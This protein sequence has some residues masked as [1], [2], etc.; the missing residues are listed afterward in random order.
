MTSIYYQGRWVW[1]T[2]V[3]GI[4]FTFASKDTNGGFSNLAV[5]PG[6]R[7]YQNTGLITS[8][9][10]GV[11][12]E[13]RFTTTGE[14]ISPG[15]YTIPSRVLAISCVSS[16]TTSNRREFC[17]DIVMPAT[18]FINNTPACTVQTSPVNMPVVG[19]TK[20][21]GVGYEPTESQHFNITLNC[22]AGIKLMA[23]MTDVNS[24]TNTSDILTIMEDTNS[25]R[26]VG[27]RI[28]RSD[29]GEVVSF[30]PDSS[31]VGNTN[32]WLISSNTSENTYDLNFIAKY[33][34][35]SVQV[36]PGVVTALATITLSY[37]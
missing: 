17:N 2:G 29:S 12:Y 19:K 3:P 9:G 25:A 33:V 5:S 11:Q 15:T 22:A 1:P 37:Q 34:Q 21:L 8:F 26:G 35:T 14:A 24:P 20:F 32:Q 6:S 7:I 16:G 4:G 23:T 31:A 10:L 28:Y 36:E 13:L 30:G 27:I 18:Q